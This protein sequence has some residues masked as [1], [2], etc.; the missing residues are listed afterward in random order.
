MVWQKK[1]EVLQSDGRV[2]D[3]TLNSGGRSLACRKLMP[4][5][6]GMLVTSPESWPGPFLKP[7]YSER[8]K[9]PEWGSQSWSCVCQH[10]SSSSKSFAGMGARNT[11]FF[12]T[13][14]IQLIDS[15][16]G[17]S[18]TITAFQFNKRE[19][20]NSC[21]LASQCTS[22]LVAKRPTTTTQYFF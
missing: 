2:D 12:L 9:F 8:K 14:Y 10:W 18:T 15:L 4:T 17:N 7:D 22:S 20:P 6:I 21:P 16:R 1:S 3:R 19:L 11:H 13:L 5:L